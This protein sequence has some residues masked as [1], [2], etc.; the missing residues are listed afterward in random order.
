MHTSYYLINET[1]ILKL[2]WEVSFS[3]YSD[4]YLWKNTTRDITLVQVILK[5]VHEA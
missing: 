4:I 2:A 3:I 5:G 1:K